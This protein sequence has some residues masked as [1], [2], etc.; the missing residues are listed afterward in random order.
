MQLK[1]KLLSGAIALAAFAPLSLVG[2]HADVVYNS[3]P[4]SLPTNLPSVGYEATSTSEFGDAVVLAGTARVL[5][6]AT[7]ILSNWALE[8]SYETVGTSAGY[9]EPMTLNLYNFG[10]AGPNP[11]VG[12]LVASSTINAFIPWR[13]E[14]TAGCGSG[15]GTSPSCFNGLAVPL[16]FNFNGELLPDNVIFGLAFNTTDYGANPTHVLGPYD[17]LNFGVAGLADVTVG[18]DTNPDGVEWNTSAQGFLT[19]GTPGVFGPDT[20]WSPFVPAIQLD[21]IP[22]PASLALLST[23]MVGLIATRRRRRV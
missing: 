14:A 18:T 5:T 19:T 9:F 13:P 7:V 16:T 15:F 21:A 8:S 1:R 6:G 11:L 22:E 2:A 3:I 12:S 4:T 20:G 17:S 10:G 23:A